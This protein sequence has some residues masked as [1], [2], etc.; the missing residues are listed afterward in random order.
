MARNQLGECPLIAVF[1]I[2]PKQAHV[3]RGALGRIDNF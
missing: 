2:E 3:I 1:G